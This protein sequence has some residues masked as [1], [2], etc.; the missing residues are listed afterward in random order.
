MK[1][2]I[3]MAIISLMI[4]SSISFLGAATQNRQSESRLIHASYLSP[5]IK[6]EKQFISLEIPDSEEYLIKENEPLLPKITKIYTFPFGTEITGV[7]FYPKQI[8]QEQIQSKIIPSPRIMPMNENLQQVD[9]QTEVNYGTDPY[10]NAWGDYSVGTGIMDG[11]RST[12][13]TC[14]VF[15]VQYYPEDNM[16]QI[17]SSVDIDINYNEPE[18]QPQSSDEIYDLIIITPTD[19]LT[20]LQPLVTHKQSVNISAKIVLLDEIYNGVY[21]PTEGRDHQENIKYFIKNAIENWNTLSVMLV[22]GS[23]QLPVRTTHIKV[24]SNDKEV[25]VSDLYYADI[26][27]DSLGF[28]SWDTNNNDVFA[29]YDWDGNTDTIDAHPDVYLG[30]LAAVSTTEVETAVN[31]IINYETSKAY[32]QNW[33]T[34]II[35]V[36]G[37]TFT[38]HSGDDSGV[39]EGETVNDYIFN[40]MDGF[41]PIRLW[42]SNNVLSGV[43][44]TGVAAIENAFKQGAGFVDFSG[45][46]NT[47]VYATHPLN[48]TIWLPTPTGGLLNTH[49]AEFNNQDK[50]PIII[51]GACSVGKFNKDPDCF[52]W[53]FVS[54]PNGGGI[55]SCGATALGYG[56][57]GSYVTQGLIERISINMFKAYDR[58]ALSI[59]EMWAQ[60]LNEY[61]SNRMGGG[62]LKTVLEWHLFG[63]P[64]LAL[65]EASTEPQKPSPPEGPT[66]GSINEEYTYM[67][68]TTDPDGDNIYYL[69]DWGDGSFSGWVGPYKSGTSGKASYSWKERGNYEIRVKAK[70]DHGVQSEWSD[71]IPISMPKTKNFINGQLLDLF[72]QFFPNLFSFLQMIMT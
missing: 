54:S 11:K 39:S 13:V 5:V 17:A 21:F 66:S 62:D 68:K 71:P 58:G 67:A 59:G 51:T 48:G 31:K 22:G 46:G 50:L 45:H 9:Y 4:V 16:V 38:D 57:I 47:Y 69:F 18:N 24:S 32:T 10:P 64:T 61:I 6:Q 33:F 60:A 63:D 44:P 3:S 37:D 35:G 23:T 53:S 25:F 52:S 65:G 49:V 19:F 36:G 55:A 34:N 43:T 72:A 7:T 41:V 1:K 15:P 30:R 26:Y 12:I 28:S 56:Y 27:N 42:A 70:D 2:I 14:D 8:T 29:E 40:F 20:E